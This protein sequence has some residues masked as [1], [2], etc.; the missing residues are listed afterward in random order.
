MKVYWVK[1]LVKPRSDQSALLAQWPHI[2]FFEKLPGLL[3]ADYHTKKNI[4]PFF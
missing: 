2:L 1:T 4:K 3:L